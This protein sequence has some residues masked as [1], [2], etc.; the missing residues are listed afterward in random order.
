MPATVLKRKLI[1]K[2]ACT[3]LF[4]K[5][6]AQNTF[7]V[8]Q[9]ALLTR[10]GFF[11]LGDEDFALVRKERKLSVKLKVESESPTKAILRNLLP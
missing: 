7:G 10:Q 4:V 6:I 3:K 11:L 9:V 2:T 1:Q 5:A 8:K